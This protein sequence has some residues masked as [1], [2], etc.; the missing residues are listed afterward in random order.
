MTTSATRTIKAPEYIIVGATKPTTSILY[1][2]RTASTG[3]GIRMTYGAGPVTAVFQTASTAN[4]ALGVWTT[5][6]TT[7]TSSA[8]VYNEISVNT[9]DDFARIVITACPQGNAVDAYIG[10]FPSASSSSGLVSGLYLP[11]G[12]NTA[13]KAAVANAGSTLVKVAV[14]GDSIE[15]GGYASDATTKPWVYV[16][17]AA[18]QAALGNGGGGFRSSC[19]NTVGWN[20][21]TYTGNSSVAA[22]LDTLT[23]TWAVTNTLPEGPGAN[24]LEAQTLNATYAGVVS[25]TSI[26]LYF[27][28]GTTIA[29]GMYSVTIDGVSQGA[30]QSTTSGAAGILTRS[31]TGLSSGSHTVVITATDTNGTTVKLFYIG[32]EGL[33]SSG[34]VVHNYGRG[35]YPS[36][37]YANRTTAAGAWTNSAGVTY[38]STALYGLYGAAGK[39]SGGSSNPAD[40]IV[41]CMSGT[42]DSKGSPNTPTTPAQYFINVRDFLQDAR[43]GTGR[44]GNTSILLVSKFAGNITFQDAT[45]KYYRAYIAQL[46]DMAAVYGC[47]HI[48]LDSMLNN[49]FNNAFNLGYMGDPAAAGAAGTDVVHYSDAGH[50]WISSIITP[51]VLA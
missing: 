21:A 49:S 44:T 51:V 25:G 4:A 40:L 8:G 3:F 33:N 2:P 13:W 45:T 18:V 22:T 19:M 29:F 14:V 26:N 46:T 17:R 36:Y 34:V 10:I 1:R 38:G 28:T 39:W 30:A 11:T 47:G 7:T 23:G 50:A 41:Y 32:M 16:M 37:A 5:Q 6:A 15:Q 27:L 9:P 20:N 35:S 31:F 12:W 24:V 48:N 43:D 42:N